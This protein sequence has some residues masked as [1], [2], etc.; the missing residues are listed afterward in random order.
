M[1]VRC[2]DHIDLITSITVVGGDTYTGRAVY[3][4]RR[5]TGCPLVSGEDTYQLYPENTDNFLY[6]IS[7]I[8]KDSFIVI[9][10]L[11][12]GAGIDCH[13]SG[14]GIF[15][16]QDKKG[17]FQPDPN[18]GSLEITIENYK[19]NSHILLAMD[20]GYMEG[21]NPMDTSR[22]H[23]KN[24]LFGKTARR[25]NPED[26][27]SGKYHFYLVDMDSQGNLIQMSIPTI[28]APV[29]S[30]YMPLEDRVKIIDQYRMLIGKS[31]YFINCYRFNPGRDRVV[32]KVFG[33]EIAGN[34][35]SL[36]L[37][38]VEEYLKE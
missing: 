15:E 6:R 20:Q 30:V 21:N 19:H 16:R 12:S 24:G 29:H 8:D 23:I 7:M 9:T 3:E 36:S 17:C 28:Y 32:N 31:S 34:V 26:L 25:S 33:E 27:M 11:K 38:S 4:K 37:Y 13:Y 35:L 5:V 10:E 2:D 18:E 1:P 22:V 14:G